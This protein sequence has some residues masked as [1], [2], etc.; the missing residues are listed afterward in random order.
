MPSEFE[1]SLLNG[2]GAFE[3]TACYRLHVFHR[4]KNLLGRNVANI[5]SERA[6]GASKMTIASLC[7]KAQRCNLLIF[8]AGWAIIFDGAMILT[9]SFHHSYSI[10]WVSKLVARTSKAPVLKRFNFVQKLI[11]LFLQSINDIIA[12]PILFLF[13]LFTE[14]VIIICQLTDMLLEAS[15]D[16]G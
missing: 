7:L 3:L 15:D 1:I 4:L 9:N 16:R 13:Y 11:V 6:R 10:K 5:D 14:P 8:K 12:G 2:D